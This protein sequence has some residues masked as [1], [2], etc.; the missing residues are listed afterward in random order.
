MGVDMK[1]TTA[2]RLGVGALGL[3]TAIAA[4]VGD[5]A[6]RVA[7]HVA[8]IAATSHLMAFGGRSAAQLHSA[9]GGKILTVLMLSV[10]VL[11]LAQVPYYPYSTIPPTIPN[12]TIPG[13]IS[14]ST[15]PPTAH[16][17]TAF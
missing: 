10:P 5:L 7:K 14:G 2:G 16:H 8:P 4:S 1:R 13:N 11:A 15:P 3:L 6:V 9:I 12:N 17:P